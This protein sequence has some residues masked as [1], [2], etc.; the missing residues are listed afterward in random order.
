MGHTI[1]L[2]QQQVKKPDSRVWADYETVNQFLEGVCK[3]YEEQLKQQN[4]TAPTITYDISQLFEFI[5]QL[6]DLSCLVFNPH[7]GTYVPHTKEWIK[8]NIYA[9]LRKQAGQSYLEEEIWQNSRRRNEEDNSQEQICG[10]FRNR[11]WKFLSIPQYFESFMYYGLLQCLDHILMVYTFL[12]L[13]CIFIFIS[14]LSYLFFSFL[15][16]WMPSLRPEKFTLYATDARELVKF[17]FVCI[18][19]VF[20]YTFDSSIA[21]HEIRTQSIIKIYIFF[22][23]LETGEETAFHHPFLERFNLFSWPCSPLMS[24][25]A[26]DFA[27][28]HIDRYTAGTPKVADRLL[29]A[30]YLDAVDDVLYTVSACLSGHRGEKPRPQP[31]GNGDSNNQETPE[32]VGL[33]AFIAQYLF[34]L[35]CLSLHCLLLLAQVTT[36]NVAFNSQNRS[37]LTVMISNNFVELKSN[38]FRK[39]GKSNLFQIACADVRERFHYAVWLFIIVCRNM[40]A[41]GWQYDDFLDLLPDILLI[42]L[43]EFAVDWIKHAFI[44]KF[45]VIASDVYE[46]YTVSIAYDL[47]LC[48]QGKNT[49]DYFE[50]LARRMGLTPI[51]LSCLINVMMI[52]TVKSSWI[53]VFLLLALPLLFALKVLVHIILLNRAYAHVHAYTQMMTAKMAKEAAANAPTN[54]A[55]NLS[56]VFQKSTTNLTAAAAVKTASSEDEEK[57]RP[58][59]SIFYPPYTGY[60]QPT[61]DEGQLVMPQ[62]QTRR[63]YSDTSFVAASLV[64]SDNGEEEEGEEDFCS[65]HSYST[66]TSVQ[67]RGI[68][69]SQPLSQTESRFRQ[70]LVDVDDMQISHRKT[71]LFVDENSTPRASRPSLFYCI[72]SI[73]RAQLNYIPSLSTPPSGLV[74]LDLPLSPISVSSL[75]FFSSPFNHEPLVSS[76]RRNSPARARATSPI[77]APKRKCY[78]LNDLSLLKLDRRNDDPAS[79]PVPE[80]C[81]GKRVRFTN[82]EKA[83]SSR[84]RLHTE[85]EISSLLILEQ[86]SS[87]LNDETAHLVDAMDV[88]LLSDEEIA[89]GAEASCGI[90]EK[91]GGAEDGDKI[92]KVSQANLT[93]ANQGDGDSVVSVADTSTASVKQPLSNRKIAFLKWFRDAS[94]LQMYIV[95]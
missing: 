8:E 75:G 32:K 55:T 94:T 89:A 40:S 72:H 86:L 91:R 85:N 45:N 1:L 44:S 92:S 64:K 59:K 28:E 81:S 70:F 51:S 4:P 34:A 53:Y 48:R 25:A 68:L 37:L 21:Y 23:L 62:L 42:L 90:K 66:D 39:M 50:L 80:K 47:L 7:S 2:L 76:S 38:V 43:S 11:V 61:R 41:S 56:T 65:L 95:P 54:S 33:G 69:K 15:G 31:A 74:D 30:V 35:V 71:V 36:L 78:S 27:D 14:L 10:P 58:K 20:L 52:Q 88:D 60:D 13:R 5:D 3:I 22:N 26:S 46:E 82:A 19:T 49:S 18:C 83:G 17:S 77:C 67:Q 84:R 93:S 57:G 87:V 12:P 9:L 24:V 73:L 63:S 29:S 6:A 16:L 79:N